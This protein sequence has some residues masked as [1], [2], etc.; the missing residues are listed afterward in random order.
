[1]MCVRFARSLW[2]AALLL[3]LASTAQAQFLGHNFG[4]DAGLLAA[5]QPD[6]GIYIAPLYI[7][8]RGDT[9]RDKNGNAIAIDPDRRG[10]LD[11]NAWALGFWH[12]TEK[13]LFGGNYSYQIA[14]AWSDNKFEAPILGLTEKVGMGFGDL[15]VQPINLG[16]H[17]E[18][19]DYSAAI[20]IYA[21]TGS[22]EAGADDNLGLGMWTLEFVGGA[23]WYLDESRSWHFST[24]ASYEI[25]SE[26]EDSNVRVGDIL[27]LEGG[28]GK[29]FMD[30][31]ASVGLAY[32]AQWKITD[33]DFGGGP[34]EILP[35]L[36]GKNRGYGFGPEV[37][38]PLATS[39][40]LFGF[41][42]L[43]YLWETGV[44]NSVEGNMLVLTLSFPWGGIPL[45]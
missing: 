33:D 41:L 10:S 40:N 22:Y 20:G 19:A 9:L 32:Y 29:S 37:N 35:G 23:T 3:L 18:R 15:Y 5:S 7:G 1:M 34:A 11:V 12:V 42:S 44:R 38:L 2:T 6:P 36:I 21:P 13:T 39:K 31:A 16:W 26:K 30:G 4:G 43:R 17:K 27:T 24:L 14:P 45:Q 8:Y 28:I 25:H